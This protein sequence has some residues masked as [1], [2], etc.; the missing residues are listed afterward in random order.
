MVFYWK[1]RNRPADYKFR[2]VAQNPETEDKAA[3]YEMWVRPYTDK[4]EVMWDGNNHAYRI[5]SAIV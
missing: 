2:V 4:V 1:A 3:D 5:G